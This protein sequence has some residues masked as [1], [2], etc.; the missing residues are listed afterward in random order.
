[1]VTYKICSRS[2]SKSSKPKLSQFIRNVKS[3]ETVLLTERNWVVA[4]VVPP[5]PGRAGRIE[6]A[7]LAEAV[8]Q[9]MIAPAMMGGVP[10][11]KP[12]IKTA[13]LL[14]DLEADRGER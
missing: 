8:R 6:D 2:A 13:D 11:S 14:K 4:E 3:G 7:K 10:P 12:L 9:G 1:M 5:R